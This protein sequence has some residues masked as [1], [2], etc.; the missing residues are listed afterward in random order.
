MY[1]LTHN[2]YTPAVVHSEVQL[3]SWWWNLVMLLNHIDD[4]TPFKYSLMLNLTFI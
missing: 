2:V 3:L 4:F 1:R